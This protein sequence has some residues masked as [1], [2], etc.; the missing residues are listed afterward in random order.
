MFK[1]S[2]EYSIGIDKVDQQH[3]NL[4]VLGKNLDNI[5][6]ENS[7]ED[8]FTDIILAISELLE[9]TTEHFDSEEKFMI[10]IDYP[11]LDEQVMEHKKMIDYIGDIDVK[12]LDS[13]QHETLE[14]LVDFLS[15]WILKHI[16]EKDLQITEFLKSRGKDE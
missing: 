7:D 11:K 16:L 1:W 5:V 13:S 10:S 2:N 4:F 9:Y 14:S 8:N 12:N 15:N 3:K 6:K